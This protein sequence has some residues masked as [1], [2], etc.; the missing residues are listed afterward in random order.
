MM[1]KPATVAL[2]LL[3]GACAADVQRD[4]GPGKE[5]EA[6]RDFIVVSELEPLKKIRLEDQIKY[7]YV[8]D[9]YVVLPTKRGNYLVEFRG[10]CTELRAARW[11]ADMVDHRAS[12]RLLYADHDSIRGCRINQ[13]YG[14]PGTM[15]DEL[16][17]LGDAP[18]DST[19]LG[20]SE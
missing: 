19:Y 20:S 5:L 10:R 16:A 12:A 18:G 17:A 2:S 8:N 6:V 13:F 15:L 7:Y 1:K 4:D 3:L 11:S 9:H 14:L